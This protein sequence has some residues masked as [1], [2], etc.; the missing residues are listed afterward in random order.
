MILHTNLQ[1]LYSFLCASSA[2]T[3]AKYQSD[4][5][6]NY[7]LAEIKNRCF[8]VRGANICFLSVIN[9]QMNKATNVHLKI[10][11]G[12]WFLEVGWMVHKVRIW[13]Q[14]ITLPIT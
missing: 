10:L 6:P 12:Q 13:S 14:F 5:N 3:S 11:K 9:F 8:Q 1:E 7:F 2:V 4:L